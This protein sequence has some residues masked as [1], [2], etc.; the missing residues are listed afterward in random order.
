MGEITFH[1]DVTPALFSKA[2]TSY[3]LGRREPYRICPEDTELVGQLEGFTALNNQLYIHALLTKSPLD[4]HETY[5]ASRA[6]IDVQ[7]DDGTIEHGVDIERLGVVVEV[8]LRQTHQNRTT[9]ELQWNGYQ[10]PLRCL[11]RAGK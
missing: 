5:L 7:R 10:P 8:M 1:V 4:I 11:N 3:T 2:L 9:V 6:F